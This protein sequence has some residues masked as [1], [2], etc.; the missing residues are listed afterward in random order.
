MPQTVKNENWT[1]R[2]QSTHAK[3]YDTDFGELDLSVPFLAKWLGG[4][5]QSGSLL[6]FSYASPSLSET[7]GAKS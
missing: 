4:A 2:E 1:L 7:F 3:F 6:P 5:F